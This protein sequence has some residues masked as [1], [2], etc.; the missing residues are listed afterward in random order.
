MRAG[1]SW[2]TPRFLKGARDAD[3]SLIASDHCRESRVPAGIAE[4]NASWW[5]G[6]MRQLAEF[7]LVQL[8]VQACTAVA[9]LLLVRGMTKEDYALF[10]IVNAMQTTGTVLSENGIGLALQSV[11]GRVWSDRA[12]FSSLLATALAVRR[13]FTIGA[14]AVTVPLS[15]WML[16]RNGASVP[17]A[18]GLTLCVVA[19][20]I[21]M[22]GTAMFVTALQL[23][24]EYR[25]LQRVNL[26]Q[27][28]L[29]LGLIAG[30]V[31]TR[32]STWNA[33]LVG[34]IG[35]GAQL[36]LARRAGRH[37][38]N[39]EAQPNAEDRREILRLSRQ[40][41]PNVIFFCVQGQITLLI[42]TLAGNAT[43]IAEVTALGRIAALFAIL[44]AVFSNVIGPRFARCQDLARLPRLYLLLVGGALFTLL[45]VVA[46]AWLLPG[47]FLWL[48]GAQYAGMENESLW[49]VA[50]VCV[51]QLSTVLWTLNSSKAWI[52]FQSRAFIP[53]ILIAQIIAALVLDLRQFHAVLI[54]NLV[55][56]IAPL[57]VLALDAWVGMRHRLPTTPRSPSSIAGPPEPS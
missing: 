23:H 48:L 29:R 5:W 31:A 45:P 44:A 50:A 14:L 11:G 56:A 47:P 25:R 54:F 55:T 30:L 27:A 36:I 39:P 40:W 18:I 9:G 20:V 52:R 19:G 8:L 24:A 35:N 42:L 57:P 21:P 53:V 7:G 16:W 37:L 51:S 6:W 12:R 32:I 43:G 13:R 3:S 17:L 41:M 28:V 46:M 1:R 49:V 26:S 4:V 34:V 22:I 10:A 33:A 2:A 38:V 15:L